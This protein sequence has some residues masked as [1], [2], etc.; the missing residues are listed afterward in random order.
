MSDLDGM[1][2]YLAR[3]VAACDAQYEAL[4]N[5]INPP[6]SFE[7]CERERFQRNYVRERW[8]REREPLIAD[9]LKYMAAD[10]RDEIMVLNPCTI[11]HQEAARLLIERARENYRPG[12]P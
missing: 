6:T 10:L 2:T 7:D 9:L 8:E 11:G 5:D 3:A 1:R 4:M 12:S